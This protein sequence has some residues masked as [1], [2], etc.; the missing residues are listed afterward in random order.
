MTQVG[1]A[2]G[3]AVP[4]LPASVRSAQLAE[5]LAE[6]LAAKHHQAELAER[7]EAQR[8]A[9]V[10]AVV[11][12]ARARGEYVSPVDVAQGRVQGHSVADVLERARLTAEFEDEAAEAR[13]ARRGEPLANY[14]VGDLADPG[15]RKPAPLSTTARA[16]ERRGEQFRASL[17]AQREAELQ[18]GR[19]EQ[20]M[21]SLRAP[22]WSRGRRGSR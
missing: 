10:A 18:R 17:A 16:I 13:A 19:L 20:V 3:A 21:P 15:T 12:E 5:E 6:G 7:C 2:F 8:N 14:F 22:H 9:D 11:A 4:W 1:A